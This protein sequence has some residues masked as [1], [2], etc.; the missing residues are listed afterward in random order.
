MVGE[1]DA[2]HIATLPLA[3]GPP[4]GSA[5]G[6]FVVVDG[7]ASAIMVLTAVASIWLASIVIIII[8]VLVPKRPHD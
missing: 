1:A 5:D 6:T 2:A 8:I 4:V 7:G 3:S